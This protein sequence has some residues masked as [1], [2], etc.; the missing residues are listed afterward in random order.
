MPQIKS[1]YYT[2]DVILNSLVIIGFIW[3]LVQLVRL[4]Y[5]ERRIDQTYEELENKRAQEKERKVAM[6]TIEK[7]ISHLEE[8][9]QPK[10]EKLERKR[11]FILDKVPFVN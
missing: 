5:Y 8:D 1:I 3:F 10:I 11:K 4:K 6:P 2:L 9:Y 7:S